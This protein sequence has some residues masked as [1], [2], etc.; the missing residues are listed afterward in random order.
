MNEAHETPMEAAERA[1]ETE[2]CQ[3]VEVAFLEGIRARLPEHPA[4]IESLGCLYTEM[5]RYQEGLRADREM[6]RL[7]PHS[8]LAWYNLACSLSLT[9]QADDAFVSLEKAIALGYSDGEWMQQDEDFAPI[10][11]DARFTRLLARLTAGKN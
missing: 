6:V 10:R 2:R 11:A 8:A 1:A 5:G 9:G 4:V 7:Q 3:A